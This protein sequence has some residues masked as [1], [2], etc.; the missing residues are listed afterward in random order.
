MYQKL[1]LISFETT[2]VTGFLVFVFG[3]ADLVDDACIAAVV[4]GVDN[5]LVGIMV[6]NNRPELTSITSLTPDDA[7]AFIDGKIEDGT[8][9]DTGTGSKRHSINKC[10]KLE[11]TYSTRTSK[12]RRFSYLVTIWSGNIVNSIRITAIY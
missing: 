7:E 1:T 3:D 2:P 10:L 6:P 12:C 4:T 5:K 9:R 11:T 8:G